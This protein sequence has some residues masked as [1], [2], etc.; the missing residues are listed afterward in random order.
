MCQTKHFR[1]DRWQHCM[2]MWI[3]TESNQTGKRLIE[4]C[5]QYNVKLCK[6]SFHI[7][8]MSRHRVTIQG[9]WVCNRVYWTLTQFVTALHKSLS[10]KLLLSVTAF[11]AQLGNFFRKLTVLCFWAHV[12][13]GWRPSHTYLQ[14]QTK[15]HNYSYVTTKG[16][17]LKLSSEA[18]DLNLLLS[19][20]WRF[21]DAGHLLGRE[22]GYVVYMVYNCCW[23]SPAQSF[24]GPGSDEL[25]TIFYS[26]RYET[27]P[28]W[29]VKS[30]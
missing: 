7:R 28:T 10:Q 2:K 5:K 30:S 20:W 19:D 6:T 29:R 12:L 26:F 21:I 18:K 14:Y 22:D 24:L 3:R 4:I 13:A 23:S 16:S 15:S 11:T 17:G 9:H 27:P 8:M 1:Y 25:L